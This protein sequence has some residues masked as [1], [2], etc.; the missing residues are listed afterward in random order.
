MR[1]STRLPSSC[2]L[3]WQP[4]TQGTRWS[5]FHRFL[6]RT[7]YLIASKSQR[8]FGRE[9]NYKYSAK[10]QPLPKMLLNKWVMRFGEAT[11]IQFCYVVF[12]KRCMS[13][14]VGK[15]SELEGKFHHN[16][17][18]SHFYKFSLQ[19]PGERGRGEINSISVFLSYPPTPP[20]DN[21]RRLLHRLSSSSL[22]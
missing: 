15:K 4:S 13:F 16:P 20:T 7:N 11:K 19:N 22:P 17:A 1:S 21:R 3:V 14:S 18:D 8:N 5:R 6:W 2:W 9:L 10:Q 12:V